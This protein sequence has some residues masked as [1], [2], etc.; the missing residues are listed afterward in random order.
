MLAR[1]VL[2]PCTVKCRRCG[3]T[4]RVPELIVRRNTGELL[5]GQHLLASKSFTLR[6]GVC[7][8]ES[9]YTTVEMADCPV[10]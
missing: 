9:V 7:E 8:K 4:I 6:C 1:H 10:D 2:D 3:T 5:S